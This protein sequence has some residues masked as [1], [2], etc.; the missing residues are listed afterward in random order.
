MLLNT[1]KGREVKDKC[2]RQIGVRAQPPR[3][4][5]AKLGRTERVKPRL[6]QWCVDRYFGAYKLLGHR[7][8]HAANVNV[9]RWRLLRR[10]ILTPCAQ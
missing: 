8:H 3:E 10:H 6:H 1:T 9:M 4:P 5:T 2:L 7:L